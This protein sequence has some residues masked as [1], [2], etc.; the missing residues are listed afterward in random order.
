MT[1]YIEGYRQGSKTSFCLYNKDM[2]DNRGA[3][4]AS[5]LSEG[6]V[7]QFGLD[8]ENKINVI[9][10]L[11]SAQSDRLN[12]ANGTDTSNKYWEGG[13]VTFPDLW[14]SSGNVVNR[15]N[16]VILVDDDGDDSIISKT[17]HLLGTATVY[18]YEEGKVNIS[19][20]NEISIGDTVYVHEYQG[21]VQD[22]LIVRK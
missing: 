7:I 10:L 22:I 14:V 17:P 20:K 21:K 15:S 9:Q 3:V 1:Q 4:K 2:Y 11:Y 8:S 13:T 5:S 19:N 6:D 16:D 18:L 12:I